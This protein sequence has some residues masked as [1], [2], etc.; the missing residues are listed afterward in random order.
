MDRAEHGVAVADAPDEDPDADEVV[1]VVELAAAHHH[2]LVHGVQL[3]RPPH[4]APADAQVAQI[5][6]DRLDDALHVLLALRGALAHQTLDLGVELGMQHRERQVLELGLDRLDAE[7]MRQRRVDLEGLGRLLLRLLG[8]HEA[9]RAR[10]VQPVGELDEQH[11][12]VARHRDDHLANGLSLRALA[13]LDLVELRDAV[14]EH[15]DFV[16]ELRRQR[17]EAVVRVLDGVV[18]QCGSDRPRPESRGRRGSARPRA[19]A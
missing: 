15:R 19:G 1:D 5:G 6:V 3:L 13:V 11:T 7:A 16:A 17:V 2:L 18:Q 9:P 10:V 12:D 14:D 4:H 8:R